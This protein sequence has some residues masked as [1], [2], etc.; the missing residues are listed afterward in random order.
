MSTSVAVAEWIRR[1]ADD[2]RQRD[3]ARANATALVARKNDLVGRQGRRLLDDLRAAVVRDAGAFRDEFPGDDSRAVAVDLDRPLGGFVVHKPAPS[4]VSLTV[5]ASADSASLM[6]GYRFVPP[7]GMPPRED[8]VHIMFIDDG[9]ETLC[10]KHHGTG[11]TFSSCE[12]LS[13]F[14]LMPVFTGRPR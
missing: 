6:C 9:R 3:T 11:N 10:M 1:V 4:A 8:R 7:G 5:T 13:E 2:E 14:L 12:A